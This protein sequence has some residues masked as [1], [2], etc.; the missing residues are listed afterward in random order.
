[1]KWFD[2]MSEREQIQNKIEDFLSEH[3]SYFN[4]PYGIISG[5]TKI[6]RGKIRSITFGV[7]RYLDAEIQ[8]WTPKKIV[9]RCQGGLYYKF[10][11]EYNSADELI[12]KFKGEIP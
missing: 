2:I 9:V 4:A 6:G 7:S 1:M 11:G 12:E 3:S 10:E 5:L 8:I